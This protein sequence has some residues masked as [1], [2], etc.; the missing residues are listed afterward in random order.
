MFGKAVGKTS[1]RASAVRRGFTLVELLVVIGIIALLISILLPALNRARQQANMVACE[2]NLRSIGQ[3]LFIYADNSKNGQLPFGG[4]NYNGTG[5]DWTMMLM[6]VMQQG[7]G[8]DWNSQYSSNALKSRTR[9][10][11]IC[12]DAPFDSNGTYQSMTDY[13]SHPRIMP[14]LGSYWGPI[15]VDPETDKAPLR[16][17]TLS[18]IK[19]AAEIGLIFDAKVTQIPAANGGGWSVN[20]TGFPVLTGMDSYSINWQ[21]GSTYSTGLTNDYSKDGFASNGGQIVNITDNSDPGTGGPDV[22]FRHMNNT[23]MNAL[24]CD[25]HVAN[26]HYKRSATAYTGYYTDLLRKNVNVNP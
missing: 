18:R 9:K 14:D 1:G 8:T 25:G 15:L 5:S 6:A 16:P 22:R 4:C 7:A 21:P 20:G 12:P 10:V 13:G 17:Y 11:F 19:S 2:A 26:F 23:V 24:M 3:A